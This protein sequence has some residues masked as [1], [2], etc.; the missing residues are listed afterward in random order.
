MSQYSLIIP[1]FEENPFLNS[2]QFFPKIICFAYVDFDFYQPTIDVL[3]VIENKL[4]KGSVLIVDDYDY[5]STGAKTA[6][7]EWYGKNKENYNLKI[8]KTI[9][10]NFAIVKK[11]V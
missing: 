11:I 10:S 7:D 2:Y 4:V 6:V 1:L 3:N 8:I 5:F 9:N